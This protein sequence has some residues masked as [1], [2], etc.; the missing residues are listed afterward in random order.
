[1]HQQPSVSLERPEIETGMKI[2]GAFALLIGLVLMIFA[3]LAYSE[4]HTAATAAKPPSP[5]SMPL[6][7]IVGPELFDPEHAATK[8]TELASMAFNRIYIIGG[9]SLV[10]LAL[11]VLLLM[12]KQT[13]ESLVVRDDEAEQTSS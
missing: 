13:P 9:A 6:T 3:V 2:F 8:P 7:K 5:D 11:G 4:L 10:S 12:T 1:M